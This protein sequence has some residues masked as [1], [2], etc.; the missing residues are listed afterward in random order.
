MALPSHSQTISK[1]EVKT[2]VNE[3]GDTLVMMN[4]EDA[5]IILSD[6]MECE[7]VDSLLSVYKEKDSLNTSTVTLQK[8]I[9]VK[10]TH[11]SD[12]QQLQ[13]NNFESILANKDEEVKF[14]D[15]TIKQQKKEIRK[16]KFLK[17]LGFTGSI[18]LP[19]LILLAVG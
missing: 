18:V 11:K 2:L 5:R 13:I 3:A 1:G 12:N 7:I 17:I 15:E 10:L 19:I 9:I 16:Q 4:L 14:K 6:L 8:D